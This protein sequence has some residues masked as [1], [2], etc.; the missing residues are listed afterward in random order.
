MC[1][2]GPCAPP[3]FA[4]HEPARDGALAVARAFLRLG[5]T[6]F[7]GPVAHLGYFRQEFVQRR[8]WLTDEAY[9]DV[10]ALCQV[11]P[12]PASSQVGMALGLMRAGLPGLLAAWAAFTLPSAL[13]MMALAQGLAHASAP[14]GLLQGLRLA[15]VAV[16]ALA[17]W[18]MTRQLCPDLPRRALGLAAA[19]AALAAPEAEAQLAIL[20]AAALLGMVLLPPPPW[21]GHDGLQLPLGRVASTTALVLW[22]VLLVSLL[23]LALRWGSPWDMAGAFYRAGA[24]VFGGGHV[25]LPLLHAAVV[26]GQ[27]SEEVFMAGYGAAQAVPGPLFTFA[28][29]LGAAT[30]SG[31]SGWLAGG[32]ALL[33]IFLPGA[34]LVIGALPVWSRMRRWPPA[35]AAL[36]ALNSAVV[37]LLAAALVQASIHAVRGWADAGAVAL[38]CL[39]LAAGLPPWLLVLAAAGLGWAAGA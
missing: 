25:V 32:L 30:Q 24:L 27:V 1:S 19:M 10:V 3:P 35:R 23:A 21:S 26:P 38:G 9:A 37:G 17:V 2:P 36:V 39:A 33:A 6:S 20:A 14:A 8:R 22:G 7:G 4:A 12:G 34:L 5:F 16:V 31:P 18:G 13:L 28:A 29:F 15:A 11:L